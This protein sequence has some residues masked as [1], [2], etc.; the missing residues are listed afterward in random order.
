MSSIVPNDEALHVLASNT[1]EGIII[2]LNLLKFRG[3]EEAEAYD[4]YVKSVSKI[5][6]HS[7][8]Q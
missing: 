2:M 8:C 1:D 6:K 5:L 7:L 3:G 4:R